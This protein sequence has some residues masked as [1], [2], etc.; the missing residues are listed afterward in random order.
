MF[1]LVYSLILSGFKAKVNIFIDVMDLSF[2][3]T[4]NL[5]KIVTH[6]ALVIIALP[7]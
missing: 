1:R 4:W 5:N 6:F 2:M 7:H 3:H